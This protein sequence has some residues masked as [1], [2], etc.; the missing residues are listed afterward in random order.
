MLIVTGC[1]NIYGKYGTLGNIWCL[2]SLEVHAIR[3]NAVHL[4]TLGV[5]CHWVSAH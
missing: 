5:K 4:E 2:V 3:V 1:M